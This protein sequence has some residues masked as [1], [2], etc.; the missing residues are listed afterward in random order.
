[1]KCYGGCLCAAALF[2][3]TLAHAAELIDSHAEA[4]DG[5]YR[6]M[7]V[8]KVAVPPAAAY[9]ALTDYA[10]LAR[11]N[12][13]ILHSE[14]LGTRG[15]SKRVRLETRACV[16]F[17]CRTLRQVEDVEELAGAIYARLEPAHSDFRSGR[18]LWEIAPAGPGSRVSFRAELEPD[19]WVPPLVG[20]WAVKSALQQQARQT[21]ENLEAT[22][23][24]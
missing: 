5:R 12:P 4:A 16:M 19:V 9:A 13:A 21:I 8:M 2:A 23:R 18:L 3:G 14:V 17:F 20:T 15:D 10:H 1:M 7:V 6:V 22:A 11:L 24:P